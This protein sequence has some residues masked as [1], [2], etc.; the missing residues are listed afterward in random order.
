LNNN[1]NND[2]QEYIK[3]EN[4]ASKAVK[5]AKRDFERK[6]VKHIRSDSKSFFL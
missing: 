4:K 5:L 2:A 3:Q 6:I 1:N